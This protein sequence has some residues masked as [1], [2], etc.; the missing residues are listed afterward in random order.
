VNIGNVIE[1][2]LIAPVNIHALVM[3]INTKSRDFCLHTLHACP[4][5]ED[6]HAVL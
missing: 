6:G 4:Y 2:V 1:V 3:D 5:I